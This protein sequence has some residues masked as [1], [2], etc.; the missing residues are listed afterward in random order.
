MLQC[1]EIELY[2]ICYFKLRDSLSLFKCC[3]V[4]YNGA[5]YINDG[6]SFIKNAMN[7]KSWYLIVLEMNLC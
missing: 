2:V 5:P 1:K 7:K 3:Y 4:M 6:V